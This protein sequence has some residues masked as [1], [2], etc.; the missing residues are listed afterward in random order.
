M[1]L[2]V[3]VLSQ[4]ISLFM[5]NISLLLSPEC[6]EYPSLIDKGATYMVLL[7]EK[8]RTLISEN[9][10][11]RSSLPPDRHK[12]WKHCREYS[13]TLSAH[14]NANWWRHVSA[15]IGYHTTPG[16]AA[17]ISGLDFVMG[18]EYQPSGD[19][20]LALLQSPQ[21][22][23]LFRVVILCMFEI[24]LLRVHNKFEA[25]CLTSIRDCAMSWQNGLCPKDNL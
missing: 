6:C 15:E 11:I 20:F 3:L 1:S 4:F 10:Q 9:F 7:K 22:R 8:D 13:K 17:K 16:M 24:L 23:L 5:N 25:R 14:L 2:Y 18:T 12:V 21:K 19:Q